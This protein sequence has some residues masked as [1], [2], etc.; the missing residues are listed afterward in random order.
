MIRS[1]D[2]RRYNVIDRDLIP[3]EKRLKDI[4]AQ[5]IHSRPKCENDYKLDYMSFYLLRRA[6]VVFIKHQ[7]AGY[8]YKYGNAEPEK[9]VE[10]IAYPKVERT[11]IAGN[12]FS[13]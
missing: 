2:K 10:E 13:A 3:A 6:H 11:E 4:I 9:A 12:K 5:A 1:F 8:H 7:R